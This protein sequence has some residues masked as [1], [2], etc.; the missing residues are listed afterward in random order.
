MKAETDFSKSRMVVAAEGDNERSVKLL[1]TD[2]TPDVSN[3]YIFIKMN[4][5]YLFTLT[6]KFVVMISNSIP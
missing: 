3:S 2:M 6:R 5:S 4:C 1:V